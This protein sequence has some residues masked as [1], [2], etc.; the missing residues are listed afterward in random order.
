MLDNPFQLLEAVIAN[1]DAPPRGPVLDL[2]AGP[3]LVS[4]V[5]FQPPEDVS[6]LPGMTAQ[7]TIEVATD[8]TSTE[9]DIWI[10][11]GAVLG[12]DTGGASV[13]TIDPAT[14][15]ASR[16]SVVVGTL[17]GADINILSGLESGDRIAVSGVHNLREGMEVR[18][19]AD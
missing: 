12:D 7:V 15:R 13:W 8:D 1:D 5:R 2:H 14:M 3:E 16:V 17:S 18:D 11:S 19:L 4:E 9:P 10:P 6:L